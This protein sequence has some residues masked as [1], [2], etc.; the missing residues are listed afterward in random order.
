MND[1]GRGIWVGDTDV[2]DECTDRSTIG[3]VASR[4]HLVTG[5]AEGADGDTRWVVVHVPDVHNDS[6]VRRK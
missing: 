3:D 4:R 6:R 2:G 5:S 1:V